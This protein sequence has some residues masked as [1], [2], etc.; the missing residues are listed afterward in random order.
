MK[1]KFLLLTAL[2]FAAPTFAH[3]DKAAQAKSFDAK[4]ASDIAAH[5]Y[6]TAAQ[7][8]DTPG[9]LANP[10][11]L[12]AYT[13]LVVGDYAMTINYQIFALKDLSPS[14]TIESVRGKPGRY[15]MLK[16]QLE[17]TLHK[18]YQK[19]PEDPQVNDAVGYYLSHADACGC[20]SLMLFKDSA[21]DDGTY[22][23][24]AEK[25]GISDAWSLFRIGVH[26]QQQN[27]P[28]PETA[29]A[30]YRRSL[31]LDSHNVDARYN[32]ASILFF[33]H[34]VDAAITEMKSVLDAYDDPKLNAD[35]HV[36][37]AQMLLAKGDQKDA[38]VQCREA[39]KLQ[40]W[41]PDAF[42]TLIQ[43]LRKQGRDDEYVKEV[44]HYIA[45]DYGNTFLFNTYIDT[46]NSIGLAP[47]D[48]KV[49]TALL[50]L[51][52][53]DNQSGPLYFNLG[54]MALLEQEP[55]IALQRFQRSLA[56]MKR[57]PK[58]P[59]GAIDALNQEIAQLQSAPPTP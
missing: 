1:G 57:L 27:P 42:S 38:E 9:K 36:M 22:F 24:R 53:P 18:A 56:I 54:R 40:Y 10:K 58:A 16:G 43:I 5:R 49:E 55:Q 50:T 19:H 51:K 52:L 41:H 31:A 44:L 39:L 33:M 34:K 21:A 25:G 32:T 48:R 20:A 59:P 8:L 46:L 4:L 30:Y 17:E 15:T 35:T 2:L 3:S 47:A 12:L 7:A 26:Y 29:L 14:E 13:R 11:Y 45:L 6:L 23:L 37:Y 28:K